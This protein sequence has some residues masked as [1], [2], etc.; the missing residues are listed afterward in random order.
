MNTFEPSSVQLYAYIKLQQS[1]EEEENTVL[2]DV[3]IVGHLT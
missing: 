3:A 1:A 2:T